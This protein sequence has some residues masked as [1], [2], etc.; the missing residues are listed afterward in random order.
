MDRRIVRQHS[1]LKVLTFFRGVLPAASIFLFSLLAPLFSKASEEPY[2]ISVFL[3]VQKT[4][5]YIPALIQEETLYLPVSDVFNFLKIRNQVSP[6]R[7]TLEGFL[8]DPKATFLIDYVHKQISFNGKTIAVS[9]DEL[10]RTETGLY[11]RSDYFGRIF[12]LESL[13]NF[14]SL[15]VVLKTNLDLP[16]IREQR[17]DMLRGN[18]KKLKGEIKPDTIIRQQHPFFRLGMA[19]WSVVHSRDF[20]TGSNTRLN[21]KIGGMVAGGEAVVSLNYDDNLPMNK[22]LQLYRWRYV[23]NNYKVLKQVVVGN[24]APQATSS[25]FA[26]VVGVQLTNTPTSRRRSFG[27]YILSDRTQPDWTVELWVNHTLV[28]YVKADASGFYSFTVPLI[29]GNNLVSLKFFSPSGEERAEERSIR[30]PFNFLPQNTFEYTLSAGVLRDSSNSRFSRAVFNY[31]LGRRITVGGGIEYLSSVGSG[32]SMPFFTTNMRLTART[33]FSFEYTHGV[34]AKSILTYHLPSNLQM[35]LYHIKYAKGQKAIVNNYLE[36]RKMSLSMP[37]RT[38]K[39]LFLSKLSIRQLISPAIDYNLLLKERYQDIPTVKTTTTELMFAANVSRF[40]ANLTTYSIIR[41]AFEPNLY[42][43]LSVAYRFP[44]G[45]VLRPQVQFNYMHGE[46]VTTKWEVEKQILRKGFVNFSFQRN[47]ATKISTVLLG[48]RY[49]F[50]SFR[51]AFTGIRSNKSTAVV[52][53]ASGSLLYEASTNTLVSSS[54]TQV[55][56][57][58][59]ILS[60]FL[61]I[62]G[63]GR[64]DKNEPTVPGLK[65]KINNG[66]VS[67]NH[68]ANQIRITDLEPYNTYV[69]E[70]DD[71]GFGNI[72]WQIRKKRIGVAVDANSMKL[73]EVPVAILGEASGMV[74]QQTEKGQRGISRILV[75]FYD[76]SEKLAAQVMSES[77]GYFSYFGLTPG[78]YTARIDTAQLHLLN[79]SSSPSMITFQIAGNEDGVVADGFRFVLQP[80]NTTFSGDVKTQDRQGSRQTRPAVGSTTEPHPENK[81]TPVPKLKQPVKENQTGSESQKPLSPEQGQTR[82]NDVK[83]QPKDGQ[84]QLSSRE[85]IRTAD[86][87][88]LPATGQPM[89]S[90]ARDSSLP[91]RQKPANAV[92]SSNHQASPVTQKKDVV[93]NKKAVPENQKIRLRQQLLRQQAKQ[94]VKKEQ[95]LNQKIKALM[96]EQLRLIRE[97]Q[98]LIREIQE[99]R[100]KQQQFSQKQGR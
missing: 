97:Q 54:R 73:V 69:I 59:I 33:L 30:I 93:Q 89:Q 100:M 25:I 44:N 2:E 99:L 41:G 70:L 31:G 17:L 61:D 91:K 6:G 83:L 64:R 9:G 21:V 76:S 47:V 45:I 68:Q 62:N 35:E 79:L 71:R 42:S 32:S 46:L 55:G 92:Y 63:N 90:L 85:K 1:G 43:N 87:D 20:G 56:R 3:S 57:G 8:I 95:Q 80:L 19:D 12:G 51:T 38:Q 78:S 28:D 96:I 27:T 72:F 60:P 88:K 15:S 58:G 52:H 67:A 94:V 11:L 75:N 39:L 14:R 98:K 13:F 86:R 77:D 10:I 49:D 84:D 65:C 26:P 22:Q 50:S 23:N 5:S 40:N 18:L 48:I 53:S 81:T 24:I 74:F 29:Y 7:D 16:L 66:R 36:E 37:L 34:R 82:K 4:G